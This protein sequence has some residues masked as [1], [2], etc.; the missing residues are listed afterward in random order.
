MV[1]SFNPY[2]VDSN[3]LALLGIFISLITALISIIVTI[4]LYVLQNKVNK[5]NQ[6]LNA[7]MD[8]ELLIYRTLSPIVADCY[9]AV[10]GLHPGRGLLGGPS[11]VNIAERHKWHEDRC[12]DVLAKI[13]TVEVLREANIPFILENISDDLKKFTDVCM[14]QCSNYD[15]AYIVLPENSDDPAIISLRTERQEGCYNNNTK[16]EVA[17]HDFQKHLN[18]RMGELKYS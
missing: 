3:F 9:V 15:S 2:W 18:E 14:N 5:T 12:N 1:I 8:N 6:R 16:I 11:V 13:H 17:Y 7:L 4:F 10:R